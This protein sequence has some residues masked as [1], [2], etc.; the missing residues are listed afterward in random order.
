MSGQPESGT[1]RNASDKRIRKIVIVGGGTAGWMAAARLRVA[2]PGES[3][4]IVLVESDD[5]GTVGV[6]ESTLPTMKNFNRILGIDEDEF[7][8]QTQAT[9]KLA[10]EFIDWWRLGHTYFNPL[11][12]QGFSSEEDIDSNP[13]QLPPVF[14][15]LLKATVDS[16]D[17]DMDKYSLCTVAARSNR[18]DRPANIPAAMYAYAFQFDAALYAKYLRDYSVQRGV[19]RIEGKI[20]DV[21]LHGENGFIDAVVLQSGQRIEGDL[22][23]DCT[24]FRALLIGQTLKVPYMDWSH[25]LPCDRAWAV[26]CK[27]GDHLTPYTRATAREA[28]WQWRIPLQHRVGNGYVFSSKYI[29]EEKA[30][31]ALLSRLEGP[32]LAE[33]RL[34]KFTA[35]R[36]TE[37]WAKNCVAVGLSSGFVEPLESTSIQLI[38]N[39]VAELI[40]QFPDRSCNPLLI[41][42]YNRRVSAGFDAV[43]DIV[44]VHYKATERED[45]EFWRYCKNMSVPDSLAVTM[46]L[47]RECGRFSM[48]INSGFPARQWLAVMYNQG[49]T[50]EAYP[51]LLVKLD[52]KSMRAELAKIRAGI[53]RTVESMPRHEDFIARNCSATPGAV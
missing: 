19:E 42:E 11:E 6:G 39:Y 1:C 38:Q 17:P 30:C 15:Y 47:F 18:F 21:Q 26:P 9:F 23:V 22:F 4:R 14:R 29:S 28:G 5:I 13:T 43:R 8:R 45:T 3:C 25:W 33:P 16:G 52:D 36:R 41:R 51:P 20:V 48:N 40:R 35:G 2:M 53:K 32:P 12:S 31:E 37:A 50:P 46:E 49:I 44:I 10:I 7:V 27:T 34:L 24:G